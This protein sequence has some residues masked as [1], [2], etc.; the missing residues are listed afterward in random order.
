MW[1]MK[2]GEKMKKEAGEKK[3]AAVF[4]TVMIV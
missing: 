3:M 2:V 1:P 4:H